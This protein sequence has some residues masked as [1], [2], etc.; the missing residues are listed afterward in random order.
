MIVNYCKLRLRNVSIRDSAARQD[1]SLLMHARDY[2]C[3]DGLLE[4]SNSTIENSA[5]KTYTLNLVNG[6]TT[7]DHSTIV[8]KG[9][10]DALRIRDYLAPNVKLRNS[11]VTRHNSAQF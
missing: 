5:T 1:G 2:Y 8:V 9:V 10:Y 4:I 11:L 3:T 6:N 7:I